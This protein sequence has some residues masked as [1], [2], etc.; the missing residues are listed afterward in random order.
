MKKK[1]VFIVDDSK[2]YVDELNK[3]LINEEVNVVGYSLNGE[4]A[5]RKIKLFEDIDVLIINS[6]LPNKDG[7]EILKE[8]KSNQSIYPEIGFI[9]LQ[10]DMINDRIINLIQSLKIDQVIFKDESN[11]RIIDQIRNIDHIKTLSEK[12]EVN[13]RITKILHNVGI[14][15]HIKGYNFIRH[16]VEM[17]IENPSVIGQVTKCLY[18]SI[19]VKF[20]SS[21]SKVERAIR[22]AIELG[23]SRGDQDTIDEIFGYTISASKAKPTNSEFIAMVADYINLNEDKKSYQNLSFRHKLSY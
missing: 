13:K 8:I 9:I 23:W 16:A 18:P 11:R 22:H 20:Q 19:A 7:F 6:T 2:N 1:S 15:A 4:D 14:P 12:D 17:V 5:L 21:P 10:V 3:V